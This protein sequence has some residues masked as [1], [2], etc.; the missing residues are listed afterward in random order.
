MLVKLGSCFLLIDFT[1]EMVV[2][3]AVY[4]DVIDFPPQTAWHAGNTF[5]ILSRD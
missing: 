5:G 2:K 4:F 1:A 3:L